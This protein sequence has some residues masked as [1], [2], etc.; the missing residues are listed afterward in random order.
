[1]ADLAR[2][3]D[4]GELARLDDDA[5]ADGGN[6]GVGDVLEHAEPPRLLFL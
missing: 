5:I 3:M 6:E 1:M 4:G 2:Y